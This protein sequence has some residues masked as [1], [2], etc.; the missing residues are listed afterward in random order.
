MKNIKTLFLLLLLA[1]SLNAAK[2]SHQK[3][4]DWLGQGRFD[5]IK[6]DK[7]YLND[8]E[9]AFITHIIFDNEDAIIKKALI[10]VR[11]DLEEAEFIPSFSFDYKILDLNHDGVSE[12]IFSKE[13]QETDY[14]LITRSIIQLHDY[15]ISTLYTRSVK[16]QT[17]CTLCLKES[18]SWKIKDLNQD[19]VKDIKEKY[20]LILTNENKKISLQTIENNILFKDGKI[21]SKQEQ[22]TLSQ[23]LIAHDVKDRKAINVVENFTLNDPQVACFLDF[24]NVKKKESITFLWINKDLN[25]VLTREQNILPASRYRTWMFKSIKDK[26]SYLGNWIVVLLNGD[27][28]FLDAKEFMLNKPLIPQDA[29]LTQPDLNL[30]ET[31]YLSRLT[32]P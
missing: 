16:E 23:I 25:K 6:M 18:L 12:I 31:E 29:N 14:K 11:P 1:L 20:E 21:A 10:L 15:K 24:K 13:S 26:D 8:N 28:S 3:I 32:L 9:R 4:K 17:S 30:T 5:I 19:K 22:K 7:V 2:P 27:K